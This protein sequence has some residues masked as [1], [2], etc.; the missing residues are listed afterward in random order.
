M[1]CSLKCTDLR[2]VC[3][4]FIENASTNGG[5]KFAILIPVALR[6]GYWCRSR[7]GERGARRLP[8]TVKTRA[9]LDG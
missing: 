4:C 7:G 1:G 8:P 9:G 3:R 6:A 2:T 5:S